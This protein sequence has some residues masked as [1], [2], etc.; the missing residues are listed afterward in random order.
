MGLKETINEIDSIITSINQS[1][2]NKIEKTVYPSSYL[3]KFEKALSM[4][5]SII[6]IIGIIVFILIKLAY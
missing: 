3:I 6:F 2:G 4:G 1:Y 5:Y